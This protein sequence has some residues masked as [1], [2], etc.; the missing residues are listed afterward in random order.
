MPGML[1]KEVVERIRAAR[2]AVRVLFMSGFA[3]SAANGSGNLEPGAALID[4]P[5]TRAQLLTKLAELSRSDP[6]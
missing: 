3:L 6:G 1:G 2:P 4:K 5:F